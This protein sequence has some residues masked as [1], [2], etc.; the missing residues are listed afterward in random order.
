[1]MLITAGIQIRKCKV[2]RP[3]KRKLNLV[4]EYG[5]FLCSRCE[6]DKCQS[7]KKNKKVF[8]YQMAKKIIAGIKQDPISKVR[9]GFATRNGDVG[10]GVSVFT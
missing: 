9:E 3:Q 7:F 6:A 10:I 1:M 4:C 2:K 5:D 8:L